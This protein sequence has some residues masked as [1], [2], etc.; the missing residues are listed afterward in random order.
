MVFHDLHGTDVVISDAVCRD[1]V[2]PAQK[3]VALN[4]ELIDVYSLILNFPIVGHVNAGHTF[5]HITYAP[6]LFWAK[7]PTL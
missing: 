3:V 4:V 6:V 7:L 1:A 5:Q 2:F